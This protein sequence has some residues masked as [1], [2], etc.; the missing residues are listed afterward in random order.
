MPRLTAPAEKG[1]R[2]RGREADLNQKMRTTLA[3]DQRKRE[4]PETS[5][6]Q[7]RDL[8]EK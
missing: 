1:V 7:G 5:E 4:K 3:Q 6:K 8:D 2:R